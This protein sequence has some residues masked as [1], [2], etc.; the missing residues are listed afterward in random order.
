MVKPL[1]T[2]NIGLRGIPV[3]DT[4][5]SM[6][7][8]KYGRLI[9]RG[10]NILDLARRSSY[11]ET[12][13]LLLHGELPTKIDLKDFKERLA[14]ER[15]LPEGVITQLME[16]EK[17]AHP[18]DVLQSA[19][20]LLADYDPLTRVET[21]TANHDKAVK[22]VAKVATIVAHWDRIRKGLEVVKPD[23]NLTH[24][25]NFLY[26]LK[27]EKPDA[28][29]SKFFDTCLVLHADH[30]FNPSTFAAR[31]VAS[32]RAHIYAA[33]TAALGA[34]AGELH[35]GANSK[36]M[37]MLMEIGSTDKVEEWVERKID[38][39]ERIMGLGHAVYKTTDPRAKILAK[40]SRE[41]G[42]RN[43]VTKWYDMTEKVR[44]VAQREL[45]NRKGLSLYPNVDFYS[46]SLYYSMGISPDLFTPV[47]AV[48]RV[49]GW[50]SHVIEEKF[51]EAQPKPQLY[52]PKAIYIGKYCGAENCEYVPLNQRG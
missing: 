38:A 34:L 49:A 24:A 32:T 29:T 6:V 9:Y 37:E 17:T 36:V 26:M 19:V 13:Y 23:P 52:R 35:G 27:G 4:K 47:F 21:K 8:G 43:G 12:S 46:A 7:D 10:Y 51:A 41:L 11:E 48:S 25:E 5:I 42:K 1:E 16:K 18:M 31:E 15:G 50:C 3:A 14:R 33:V 44:R 28:L 45:K 40:M 39:H 30:E 2:K 22:L 20:P